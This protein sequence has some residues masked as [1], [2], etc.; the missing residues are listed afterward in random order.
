MIKSVFDIFYF[1]CLLDSEKTKRTKKFENKVHQA[2]PS[3]RVMVFMVGSVKK[4][5]RRIIISL[6]FC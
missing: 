3:K 2:L 1:S 6:I 4:S 5:V